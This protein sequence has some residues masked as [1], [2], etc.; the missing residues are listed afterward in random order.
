MRFESFIP[1][2]IGFVPAIFM[3][4]LTLRKYSYPH[5]EK[6]LFDDR[7]VFSTLAL[8]IV[9]GMVVSAFHLSTD[10]YSRESLLMS[11]LF[12]VIAF[13]F[14]GTFI[15]FIVLNL[16]RFQLKFD[17]TFYGFSLGIGMGSAMAFTVAY[18]SVFPRGGL[19]PPDV[20]DYTALILYSFNIIILNASLGAIIGRGSADGE[21]WGSAMTA[22]ILHAI[23]N[24]FMLPFLWRSSVY[25]IWISLALATPFVLVLYREVCLYTIPDTLP[26]GIRDEIGLEVKE[27]DAPS[28][29]KETRRRKGMKKE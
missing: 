18:L 21:L 28:Q 15:K 2:I 23:Y 9:L 27:K 4:W 11:I 12:F 26:D 13:A 16:K 22:V 20:L 6:S 3:L 29:R 14:F 25:S 8:G 24:L 1:M 19:P 17:T 10:M 5:I 7:K